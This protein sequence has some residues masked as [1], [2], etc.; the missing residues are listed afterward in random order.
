[1][2]IAFVIAG[3]GGSGGGN[4]GGV[5]TPGGGGGGGGAGGGGN[6]GPQISSFAL[7]TLFFL[8]PLTLN[9]ILHHI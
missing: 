4:G 6:L 8:P 9:A 3:C 7:S 5:F 2:I 1:M